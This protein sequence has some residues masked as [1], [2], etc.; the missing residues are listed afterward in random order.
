M[1]PC[2]EALL[3]IDWR[4]LTSTAIRLP[5]RYSGGLLFGQLVPRFDNRLIAKC[6]ISGEKVP[7]R[8]SREFL[9]YRWAMQIAN[10]RVAGPDG[11]MQPL[12]APQRST[13]DQRARERGYLTPGELKRTVEGLT[14][15][16]RN[17]LETMLMHPDSKDALL[18]DPVRKAISSEKLAAVW[19]ELPTQL[20][21]R[22]VGK[23]HLG[24][25]VSLAGL[26]SELIATGGT[27]QA[28]DDAFERV[29]SR[30]LTG[31]RKR[32]QPP[33]K[34]ALSVAAIH[35]ERLD[36]RAPYGRRIMQKAI[37]EVMAG[38]DPRKRARNLEVALTPE[39]W[40][41]AEDKAEDGCLFRH[42]ALRKAEV[43]R[44]IDE[45]TNNHLVRHR[46]ARPRRRSLGKAEANAWLAG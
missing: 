43:R 9:D 4:A 31:G 28:F 39:E 30:E 15:K 25:T 21:K 22:T 20:Q 17:N 38:F 11:E 27:P 6:P 2:R 1:R 37:T 13:L 3:I 41:S 10:I 35:T 29:V 23:L 12:T 34:E 24:R 44:A 8:N 7:S 19:A 32:R 45:Q 18:V 16:A 5:A 36:G 14:S 40:K 33:S 46:A 26:R 42:E